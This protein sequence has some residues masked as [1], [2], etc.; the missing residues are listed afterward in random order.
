M[1][2]MGQSGGIGSLT[3][4]Q[5]L[6]IMT[7]T[8][9]AYMVVAL[10]II[11]IGLNRGMV[12]IF[13]NTLGYGYIQLFGSTAF[14]NKIFSSKQFDNVKDNMNDGSFNY[15]FLLTIFNTRNINEFVEA[16]TSSPEGSDN[17]KLPFDFQLKADKDQIEKLEDYIYT[18]HRIGHFSWVYFTSIIAMTISMIAMGMP[19]T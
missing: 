4:T 17:S 9:I 14:A 5:V 19:Q 8:L 7:T 1:G 3:N 2:I 18:K 12:E 10:T 11:A 16:L 15:G 6:T 13:E